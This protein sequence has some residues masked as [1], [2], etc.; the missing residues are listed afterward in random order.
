MRLTYSQWHARQY[1]LPAILTPPRR[2]P[3]EKKAP[4]VERTWYYHHNGEVLE[5][6]A[7]TRSEARARFKRLVGRR[8]PSGA[9]IEA[10]A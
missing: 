7:H 10:V 4:A 6:Q 1:Q 5:V 9:R 3:K 2:T 8:L